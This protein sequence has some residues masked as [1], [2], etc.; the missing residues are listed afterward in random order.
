METKHDIRQ[1]IVFFAN[2]NNF[3]LFSNKHVLKNQSFIAPSHKHMGFPNAFKKEMKKK[4]IKT[5]QPSHIHDIH[6]WAC[7]NGENKLNKTNK[8]PQQKKTKINVICAQTHLCMCWNFHCEL[9]FCFF[10]AALSVCSD[11]SSWGYIP[12]LR[13]FVTSTTDGADWGVSR[14][15]ILLVSAHEQMLAWQNCEKLPCASH[16]ASSCCLKSPGGE[17]SISL[18]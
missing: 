12:T 5:R 3:D 11:N 13:V 16:V 2:A 1:T 14:A 17:F 7:W 10:E 9:N 15:V 4:Q 8:L 18:S 6:Y